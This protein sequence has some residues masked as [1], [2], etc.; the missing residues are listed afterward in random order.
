MIVL[1]TLG[2][3]LI[4]T[5]AGAITPRAD[6]SFS[7]AL[8]LIAER[9]RQVSRRKLLALLWPH[10]PAHEAGPVLREALRKLRRRGLPVVGADTSHLMIPRECVTVDVEQLVTM[11]AEELL[12]IDCRILP[13]WEPLSR[14][15][16]LQDWVDDCRSHLR[17]GVIRGFERALLRSEQDGDWDLTLRIAS[18]LLEF[19]PEHE[20]A[21]L[22]RSEAV[23]ALGALGRPGNGYT[24]RLEQVGSVSRRVRIGGVREAAVP[25]ASPTERLMF[26]VGSHDTPLVGREDFM[27]VAERVLTTAV[28]RGGS[29]LYLT[30]SAGIGKSRICREIA[31]SARARGAVVVSASCEPGDIHRPLS[32]FVELLPTLRES[33][34]AA[35]CDPASGAILDALMTWQ[36][37]AS[38]AE[39][40][41]TAALDQNGRV[42]LALQDLVDAIS[43]EQPL[44]IIVENLEWSDSGSRQY[45]N[46]LI[47]WAGHR[48]LAVFLTSREPLPATDQ[49]DAR[50][51]RRVTLTPLSRDSARTHLH[52]FCLSA[53]ITA[54]PE[55]CDW[56]LEAAD[57]NP[58]F[59][60][61]LMTHWAATGTRDPAPP[62]VLGLLEGALGRLCPLALSVIQACAAL[63]DRSTFARLQ[64]MLHARDHTFLDAVD[65]LGRAGLVVLTDPVAPGEETRVAC[66]HDLIADA[67]LQ[68][69]SRPA[70][71]ALHRLAARTLEDDLDGTDEAALLW[72]C[73]E[74]WCQAGASSYAVRVG[75]S[76]AA[77]LLKVG[78]TMEAVAACERTLALCH[79]EVE[80]AAVQPLLIEA[81][82]CARRWAR[83]YEA[84]MHLAE[85]RAQDDRGAG[86]HDALEL[87]VLYAG[88]HAGR[89]SEP[90]LAGALDCARSESASPEHR[91][92]AALLALRF[93]FKLGAVQAMEDAYSAVEPFL[94]RQ[95]VCTDDCAIL[96]VM[97]HA[98]LGEVEEATTLARAMRARAGGDCPEDQRLPLLLT[99][100]TALERYGYAAEGSEALRAALLRYRRLGIPAA[101]AVIIQHLLAWHL[102]RGEYG[103]AATLAER[104]KELTADDESV[105]DDRAFRL[106]LARIETAR[107]QFTRADELLHPSGIAMWLSAPPVTRA[108]ALAAMIRL[109]I[110]RGDSAEAVTEHVE[111]LAPLNA[112]FRRL[113]GQ[114]DEVGALALGLCYIGRVPAAREL[115]D[116]Y[117][118]H[119]RRDTVPTPAELTALAESLRCESPAVR[120]PE[121]RDFLRVRK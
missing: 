9:G 97:Y 28:S 14:S 27:T 65:E 66:R 46:E 92:R 112:I 116:V 4:Q 95:D 61:E 21:Q 76:C 74:H 13:D 41:T 17:E 81:L 15:P 100:G 52:N 114:D 86:R 47:R 57:G 105:W 85:L 89:P 109:Q 24:R 6:V 45:L 2:R 39:S 31:A 23:S 108:T 107:G 36:R 77:H 90:L 87:T 83:A 104:Y 18:R 110:A 19:E 117:L 26:D 5:R 25:R 101:E 93:A 22:I 43:D 121:P 58:F 34:G 10:R 78:L 111:A 63:G 94:G 35:G 42:R 67:A 91:V 16:R 75:V 44:V 72:D 53:G 73:M 12:E 3:C 113:G 88:W 7:L 82:S 60:E 68:R 56:A 49:M 59:L 120:E 119:E 38:R 29:A 96:R 62:S 106:S 30:G 69:L 102:N 79:T 54:D 37:S 33:P 84:A 80:R 51:V 11:P 48:R 20:R 55:V 98:T 8:H 64:R 40:E 71:H 118:T 1:H 32:V 115:V 103:P 70:L 99:A 50:A